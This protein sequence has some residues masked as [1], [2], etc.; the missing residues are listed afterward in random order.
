MN[1]TEKV[2]NGLLPMAVIF[3][4]MIAVYFV[5]RFFASRGN[6]ALLKTAAVMV[7]VLGALVIAGKALGWA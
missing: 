2:M 5:Y 4:A 3:A 6:F 1:P 7:A